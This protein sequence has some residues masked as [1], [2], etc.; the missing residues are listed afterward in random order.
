MKQ[1]LL[2]CLLVIGAMLYYALPK[3]S[4]AGSMEE[5]IFTVSW[6]TFA[7]FAIAGNLA[8]I[9]YSTKRTNVRNRKNKQFERKRM[10]NYE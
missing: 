1:R 8:G 3:F 5:R 9:L 10:Y 2:I 4:L 7:L 6:L